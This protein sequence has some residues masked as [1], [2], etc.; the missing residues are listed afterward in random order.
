LGGG[1]ENTLLALK[2]AE[3]QP[4]KK[5]I[6]N[7]GLSQLKV[8]AASGA[9]KNPAPQ[10]NPIPMFLPTKTNGHN[11]A[12]VITRQSFLD[13]NIDW[14]L[15][16]RLMLVGTVVFAAAAV[17]LLFVNGYLATAAGLAAGWAYGQ[18]IWAGF[19]VNNLLKNRRLLETT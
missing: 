8:L 2:M 16:W 10:Y 18:Y 12:N 17:I 6:K 11:V 7:V 14:W 5:V 4:E 15:R 9:V 13:T 1:W 3:T 19:Y